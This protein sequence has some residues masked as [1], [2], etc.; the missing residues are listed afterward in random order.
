MLKHCAKARQEQSWLGL[1]SKLEQHY[2]SVI[3]ISFTLIEKPNLFN[4][5]HKYANAQEILSIL[6]NNIFI[7]LCYFSS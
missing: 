5:S 7:F 6:S 2:N 1:K 4:L 3:L